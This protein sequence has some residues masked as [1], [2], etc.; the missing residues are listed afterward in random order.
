MVRS[1]AKLIAAGLCSLVVVAFASANSGTD[2]DWRTAKKVGGTLTVYSFGESPFN[3]GAP[4][5][6]LDERR[7]FSDGSLAFRQNH[8]VGAGEGDGLSIEGDYNARSCEGCHL[9]DGRGISHTQSFDQ[10]GFSVKSADDGSRVPIFRD[11]LSSS[12]SNRLQAVEWETRHRIELPGGQVAELVAPV[13]I[14]DGQRKAVD[15][16]NAPGVYGLGLLEAIPENEIRKAAE[17]R[18][19]SALGVKGVVP[20]ACQP[21][22]GEP[23]GKFGRFGWKGTV[24]N[25]EV[26]TRIALAGEL[27]IYQP[28]AAAASAKRSEYDVLVGNLAQYL[29]MLAVP[30]RRVDNTPEHMQGAR[31]FEDT[32]CVMCH[33]PG[34]RTG[35]GPDTNERVRDQQIYPFTDL[36]LHDM[37]E[38]L[39]DSNGDSLSR[40]WRT[41]ALW[42]IGTQSVVSDKVGYLH[43]GR[44]RSFLEAVLWHGGEADHSICR[45]KA[46]S[47]EDRDRLIAFVA[48]L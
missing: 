28:E 45:F 16:R 3:H 4:F 43:D 29:S 44:A 36:L 41:P 20:S 24:A 33:T 26:Q 19:F 8:S 27:G 14:V 9:R 30:A 5:L 46:L 10:T 18:E 42:G 13:S 22:G 47:A 37:G 12:V 34:W 38:G 17:K 31:L 32:G 35:A 48:S 39:A 7:I 25:L 40:F 21:G 11:L 23:C 1:T 6:Q 2:E 15:L